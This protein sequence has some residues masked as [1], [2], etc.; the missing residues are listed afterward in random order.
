M[1]KTQFKNHSNRF[2]TWWWRGYIRLMKPMYILTNLHELNRRFCKFNSFLWLHL[3]V[4]SDSEYI[5]FIDSWEKLAFFCNLRVIVPL[6]IYLHYI[7]IV[8][9]EAEFL[10]FFYFLFYF[11]FGISWQIHQSDVSFSNCS[12]Y[13]NI[14]CRI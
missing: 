5:L 11:R 13:W 6:A 12:L 2:H 9:W 7:E 4:I 1:S 3:H 14:L 8:F 10:S